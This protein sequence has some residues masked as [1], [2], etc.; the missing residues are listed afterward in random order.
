MNRRNKKVLSILDKSVLRKLEDGKFN[1]KLKVEWKDGVIK[2][3]DLVTRMGFREKDYC[4]L[5]EGFDD[6]DF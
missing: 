2:C 1:G 3:F 5:F 6:D 4:E